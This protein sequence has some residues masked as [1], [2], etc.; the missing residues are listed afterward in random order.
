MSKV[1][2]TKRLTVAGDVDKFEKL[3]FNS[4][5]AAFHRKTDTGCDKFTR[6]SA[7][8]ADFQSDASRNRR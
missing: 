5:R 6:G 3:S 7:L 8:Q 4:S 1:K 2:P